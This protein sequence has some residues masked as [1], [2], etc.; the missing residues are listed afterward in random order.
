MGGQLIDATG[1]D[2]SMAGAAGGHAL[3]TTAP[4]LTMFLDAVLAGELF[5]NPET[6]EKMLTFEEA[7]P[8]GM[9]VIPGIEWEYYGYGLGLE[10]WVLPGG[11]E[12]IG[13]AGTTAGFSA[14]VYYLPAQDITIALAFNIQELLEFFIRMILPTVDILTP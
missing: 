10:K 12:L 6:L 4:D 2:P 7:D 3:V 5:Q 14:T 13:H 11:V 9:P 1:I 8:Y